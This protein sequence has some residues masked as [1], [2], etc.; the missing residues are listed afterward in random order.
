MDV[1][2]I[3]LM[4]KDLAE[5]LE[6]LGDDLARP[7]VCAAL[8]KFPPRQGTVPSGYKMAK[9]GGDRA[10]IYLYGM[11]GTDWFGDGVSAK[12]FAD[13]LKAL[14]KGIKNIDLRINSEGGDVFAGKTMYTL[15]QAHEAKIFVH[16]D[17]LAA[18][19]ASFVA[20]AGDEI[21]I[22]E[23]AFMMIHN[24]WTWAVGGAD[25]LRESAKLLDAINGTL[26]DVYTA[27]TK[28]TAADVK[29]WMDAETWMTGKECLERGFA[30]EVVEN[31]K[32][33]ASVRDPKRFKNLPRALYPRRAAGAQ[34]I[35]DMKAAASR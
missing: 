8:A 20:M 4:A 29:K 23:G 31:K 26:V 5:E 2:R 13:D 22:A 32:V 25:D 18:S 35:A 12:K 19:A 33:A 11:I 15:L 9:K 16:V 30:T 1:M 7:P 27:R 24:A 3:A 6:L 28:N 14:G 17:G 10:E 34:I 21:A